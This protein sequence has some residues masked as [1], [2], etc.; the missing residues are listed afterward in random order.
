MSGP[1]VGVLSRIPG[2]RARRETDAVSAERQVR[3]PVPGGQPL[4]EAVHLRR[5][6]RS[7][8]TGQPCPGKRASVGRAARRRGARAICTSVAPVRI[9]TVAGDAEVRAAMDPADPAVDISGSLVAVIEVQRPVHVMPYVDLH[10][11]PAEVRAHVSH[12]ILIV[13]IDGGGVVPPGAKALGVLVAHP[14]SDAAGSL[15]RRRRQNQARNRQHR[16]GQRPGAARRSAYA[17]PGRSEYPACVPHRR[18]GPGS[19]IALRGALR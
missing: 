15:D 19:G 18:A 4:P 8:E 10:H 11:H 5:G 13:E 14:V 12:A 17:C 1:G 3:P 2:F 16:R 7:P 9:G 6:D